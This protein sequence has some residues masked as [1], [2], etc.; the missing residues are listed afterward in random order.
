M[1]HILFV[2]ATIE[3]IQPFCLHHGLSAAQK[4]VQTADSVIEILITGIGMTA[5][6]LQLG[7]RLAVAPL[8]DV[9]IH[10]GIAG[11]Y[12]QEIAL[13]EVI[14]LTA[15][16]FAELGAEDADG[17]FLDLE[18]MGFPL[19]QSPLTYN[20]LYN[21]LP[22]PFSIRKSTAITVNTVQGSKHNIERMYKLWHKEIETMEGAAFF[23]AM[24]TLKLPFYS[25]RAISNYVTPRDRASWKIG[26]AIHNL[27][28]FLIE[29]Y[30]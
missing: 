20:T 2:S 14:E 12:L 24:H 19:L 10:V 3:E 22:S 26:L 6:A 27:N 1:Q 17:S 5:T 18:K 15:D 23:L 11:S 25:F 9:C 21:P 4:S 7:L 28:A 29:K 16:T 30:G 13:G 8:P